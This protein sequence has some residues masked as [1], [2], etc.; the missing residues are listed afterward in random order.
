MKVLMFGNL[1]QPVPVLWDGN[2][3][4]AVP[5]NVHITSWPICLSRMSDT[6]K[7]ML[8][9]KGVMLWKWI[10]HCFILVLARNIKLLFGG[11]SNFGQQVGKSYRNS[12]KWLHLIFLYNVWFGVAFGRYFFGSQWSQKLDNILKYTEQLDNISR[13]VSEAQSWIK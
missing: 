3:S 13:R 6:H 5:G 4:Q 8:L 1:S 10:F 7:I 11:I 2:L 9:R 12:K